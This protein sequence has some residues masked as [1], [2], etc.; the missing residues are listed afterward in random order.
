MCIGDST[1]FDE[2]AAEITT[3]FALLAP[4]LEHLHLRYKGYDSLHELSI[5]E[6]IC[7]LI[8]TFPRLTSLGV[9]GGIALKNELSSRHQGSRT[10]L[11]SLPLTDLCLFRSDYIFFDQLKGIDS[12]FVSL[13]RGRGANSMGSF[14]K[15]ERLLIEYDNALLP[16]IPVTLVETCSERGI[17]LSL[18]KV[19]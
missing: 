14:A 12:D 5:S 15:L 7:G 1:N 3:F 13:L 9:G 2:L 16:N 6:H 11:A 4:T 18:C 8:P 19:D 17:E 10:R